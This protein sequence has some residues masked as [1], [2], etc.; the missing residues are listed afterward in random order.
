VVGIAIPYNPA[1]PEDKDGNCSTCLV[2]VRGK[3]FGYSEE[4]PLT[5]EDKPKNPF[6][7]LKGLKLN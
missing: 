7:V 6:E 2:A 1:P 4:I 3:T 5:P